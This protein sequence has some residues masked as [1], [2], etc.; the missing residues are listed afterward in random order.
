[1]AD[2]VA[3]RPHAISNSSE[4]LSLCPQCD[5][6]SDSILLGLMRDELA[7]VT[8]TEAEGDFPSKIATPGLLIRLHLANALADAVALGLGK[9][10]GDRQE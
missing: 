6:L 1:M 8:A 7:I 4:R 5:H 9:G 10:G 3:F 2:W